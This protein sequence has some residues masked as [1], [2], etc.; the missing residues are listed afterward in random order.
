VELAFNGLKKKETVKAVERIDFTSGLLYEDN[1]L[2]EPERIKPVKASFIGEGKTLSATV[3]PLCFT[4][5]VIT[6]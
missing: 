4:V 6:R 2:D 3:P 5:F 1:T